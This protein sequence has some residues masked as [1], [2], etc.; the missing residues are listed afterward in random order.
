MSSANQVLQGPAEFE[1]DG[2]QHTATLESP[3]GYLYCTGSA[4]AVVNVNAGTVETTQP[5]GDDN[6]RVMKSV[7]VL[8]P[9]PDTCSSFTFK[10]A[11]STFLQYIPR[12]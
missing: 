3:G 2:T 9:L 1:A 12:N 8:V 10:A 7:G 11:S 6:I 4:D 5:S